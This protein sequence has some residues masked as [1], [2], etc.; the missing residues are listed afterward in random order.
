MRSRGAAGRADFANHLSDP[1]DIADLDVDLGQVAVACRQ[2]IAVVD[3]DQAA[4]AAAPSGRY[5]LAVRGGAHGIAC[6]CPEIQ[7]GM[8]RGSAEERVA[9]HA[10][11][12]CEFD[13]AD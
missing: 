12:G 8:H 11:A 5:H 10:E 4:I 1:D 9:A 2:T 13:L 7:A 6:L 3:F